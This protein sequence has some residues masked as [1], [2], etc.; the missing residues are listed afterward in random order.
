MTGI[1]IHGSKIKEVIKPGH[2]IYKI[3]NRVPPRCNSR[4]DEGNCN[5]WSNEYWESAGNGKTDAKITG[6]VS[7][8][9]SKMKVLGNNVAKV[10]DITI[11]TWVAYPPIPAS[12]RDTRYEAI[13]ATS[14]EGQGKII[15]GSTKGKL[16]GSP[17]ALIGS[18]VKTC[19]DTIT[20]IETGNTKINFS[21]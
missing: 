16:N 14:G 10:G 11:E 5:E 12:T 7:V 21:G 19:L 18:Q 3:E 1:A 6:T 9:S 4:D 2:V 13:G 15:S 8:P 20:T 17:I